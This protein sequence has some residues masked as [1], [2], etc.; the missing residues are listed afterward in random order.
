MTSGVIEHGVPVMDLRNT[1][2]L[3]EVEAWKLP[4]YAEN[5]DD[6][7][8][9]MYDVEYLNDVA[10]YFEHNALLPAIHEAMADLGL[11]N[12][13]DLVNSTARFYYI[14]ESSLY[15]IVTG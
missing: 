4:A 15:V 14:K 10:V 8:L 2:H 3:A 9:D 11:E 1:E 5:W 13:K 6:A 7:N 12:T